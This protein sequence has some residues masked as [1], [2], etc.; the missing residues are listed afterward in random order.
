M[1]LFTCSRFSLKALY[2]RRLE[3]RWM[4]PYGCSSTCSW[5]EFW[6]SRK[7]STNTVGQQ[8]WWS[9]S[10]LR[11][12][13]CETCL[14][15]TAALFC[16]I[17]HGLISVCCVCLFQRNRKDN[18]GGDAHDLVWRGKSELQKENNCTK[19]LL[20]PCFE[21]PQQVLNGLNV[22]KYRRCFLKIGTFSFTSQIHLNL[23]FKRHLKG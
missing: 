5:R 20:M 12:S 14:F 16:T 23:G 1:N 8:S 9:V 7:Y 2:Y 13:C 6:A 10:A 22:Q 4:F 19:S 18:R 21:S 15:L 11:S 3:C 17:S